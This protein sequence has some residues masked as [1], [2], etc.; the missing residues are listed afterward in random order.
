MR[1]PATLARSPAASRAHPTQYFFLGDAIAVALPNAARFIVGTLV[2]VELAQPGSEGLT[3]GLLTTAF[4]LGGPVAT[5]A[6]NALFGAAFHPSL[7]RPENYVEDKPSFRTT[8]AMSYV[9]SYAISLT[10]LLLLP[11]LPPQKEETQM[12]KAR[13]QYAI[14]P[15]RETIDHEA[16]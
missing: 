8:V 2:I 12:L 11:L 3:Y 10:S 15:S 4:N 9:L 14:T 16:A 13:S 1:S 7:S 6:S 5:A